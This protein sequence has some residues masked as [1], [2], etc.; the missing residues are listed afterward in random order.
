MSNSSNDIAIIGLG[1]TLRRDDGIG[2][3]LLAILEDRLKEANVK[4]LNF[5]IASFG[6][7]NYITDFKKV[8]LIDAM[9]AGLEP[10]SLKIFRPNEAS[11]QIKDNKLSSHELSLPDLLSL[12]STLKVPTD[13]HIAGVQVKDTSYGL[14]MT[15]ELEKSKGHIAE[16]IRNFLATW[17]LK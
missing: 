8:L 4:F 11:Y 5:G 12:C 9:D 14:E 3:H 13:V 10:A 1:N 15:K 7:I 2:I 16:E 6:L 17:G